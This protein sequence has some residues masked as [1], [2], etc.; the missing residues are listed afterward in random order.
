[1]TT[2]Q[3]YTLF[4]LIGAFALAGGA[5]GALVAAIS[6]PGSQLA[7]APARVQAG[8]M[9]LAR[10]GGLTVIVF[11]LLLVDEAG[12]DFGDA[13]ITTAFVLWFVLAAVCEGVVLRNARA[14]A[15]RRD[16]ALAGAAAAVLLV[17]VILV[18]MVWRPG[19]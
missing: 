19:T 12:Y 4:H 6:S 11:G 7:A 5:L 17:L 15:P 18:L 10:L 13:W 9:L 14:D 8:S 1:M 16:R 2:L 3:W